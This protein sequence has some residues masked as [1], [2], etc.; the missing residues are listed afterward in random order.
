MD[1]AERHRLQ[2][3]QLLGVAEAA[4]LLHIPRQAVYRMINEGTLPAIV[5]SGYRTL[6]WVSDIEEWLAERYSVQQ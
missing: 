4:K 5:A 1:S 6:I 3:D 2:T